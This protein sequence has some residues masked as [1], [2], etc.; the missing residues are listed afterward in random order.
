MGGADYRGCFL[1]FDLNTGSPD[2][3]IEFYSKIAGWG[4][5]MWGESYTM[6]TNQG[7]PIG[8][9][10]NLPEEVQAAGMPPHWIS[11]IGAPE[12]DAACEKVVELGGQV[13]K[14]ASDIPTVGRYAVVSDPQGAVFSLYAPVTSPA[15]PNAPSQPGQ[16]SWHELATFDYKAGWEFYVSLFGWEVI[17]NMDM[18]EMGTYQIYGKNGIPLGGMYDIPEG[19]PVPPNWLYYIQVDDVRRVAEEVTN[20]GGQLVN[21]PME[22]PGG[23]LIAQCIDPQGAMFAIHSRTRS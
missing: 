4:T 19:M 18:G 1:W 5:E 22:V 16:F 7:A 14:P 10:V 3:A 12:V 9:V 2:G 15:A 21:G 17:E 13:L 6:W 8:G 23:D 20:R 11:Y